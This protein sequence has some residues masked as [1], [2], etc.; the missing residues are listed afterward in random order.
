MT[1]KCI[2]VNLFGAPNAGESTG[3][4]YVFSQLQMRGVNAELITEYA[5]RKVW[6]ESCH[7][8]DN[9]LYVFAK[10][11]H[12]MFSC[13]DIVDVIVTDSPLLL[14]IFYNHDENLGEDF[15][16]LVQH[17]FDS[18]TNKNYLV[19]RTKLHNPKGRLQTEEEADA[20]SREIVDLLQTRQVAYQDI[21]GDVL[22]YQAV[23]NDVLDSLQERETQR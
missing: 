23:I 13:E 8:L 17:L 3:A 21:Y 19:H 14:S 1:K 15:N 2:V 12:F 18:F 16:R 6:E 5:K 22:D 4:A 10:Q 20:Y 7:T 9:P 11:Y